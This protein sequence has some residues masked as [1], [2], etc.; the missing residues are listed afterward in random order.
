MDSKEISTQEFMWF[1]DKYNS[2]LDDS[3][4]LNYDDVMN[5]FVDYKIKILE[6]ERQFLDTSAR[7]KEEFN[8]YL[9]SEAKSF[10]YPN[11]S[12]E[13]FAQM[14]YERLNKDYHIEHFFIKS[15]RYAAPADTLKEYNK[16]LKIKKETQR[17]GDL[18]KAVALV[19]K[20]DTVQ[21]K[22]DDLGYVT[23][24]LLPLNY[25]NAV[26]AAKKG[27]VVGPIATDYG[28]YV[29]KIKDIRPTFGQSQVSVVVF[30]PDAEKSDS[31]WAAIKLQADS[32]YAQLQAGVSFAAVSDAYNVQSQLQKDKG[33]IGWIDNSMRFDPQLKEA[34]FALPNVGDF[35]EPQKYDYGDVIYYITGRDSLPTLET[36]RKSVD[37]ALKNDPTRK[38]V[39]HKEMLATQRNLSKMKVNSANVEEFVK[40]VDKSILLGKWE[41]PQF[42]LNKV[43]FS[44][45]DSTYYYA[46]FAKYLELK[47]RSKGESDKDILVRK[48]LEEYQNT[49]L[50]QYAVRSLARNNPQFAAIMQEYHD[51]MIIYELL[52]KEVFA[53]VTNDS[54]GLATFYAENQQLAIAPKS[55]ELLHFTYNNE[56]EEKA[57]LKALK[58]PAKITASLQKTVPEV[59]IDTVRHFAGNKLH[60]NIDALVWQKGIYHILPNNQIMYITEVFEPYQM[61]FD[62]AKAQLIP[63][64]QEYLEQQLMLNLREKYSYTLNQEV[65]EEIKKLDTRH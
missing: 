27:D 18:S 55:I 34:I 38:N 7:F 37:Y 11:Q 6:A 14:E 54:A 31:S 33:A 8:T 41:K 19:T 32:A 9:Q 61:N 64:Y 4:R 47:Q 58:K 5:L 28:Y 44:I 30:Y 60:A 62:E 16:A 51:G 52:D 2:Y 45:G 22:V 63:F 50:E 39:A 23:S 1:Y 59:Q 43:L 12:D 29:I 25:E 17:L 24:L 3:A 20:N 10:L 49:L 48:R 36:F 15:S 21:K 57:I 42:T 53:K 13:K 46:D 40:K 26:Y 65:F 56:K 35:S